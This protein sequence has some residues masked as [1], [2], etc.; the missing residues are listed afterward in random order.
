MSKFNVYA[1]R[2]DDVVRAYAKEYRLAKAAV[3]DAEEQ[4][5]KAKANMGLNAETRC[6]EATAA[7]QLQLARDNF[8]N[9]KFNL[10]KMND[11]VSA[12]RQELV[13]A[14]DSEYAAKSSDIDMQTME[15][16]KSGILTER[17]YVD[18]LAH[19]QNHTMKRLIAEKMDNWAASL[20]DKIKATH[21]RQLAIK[22]R[23]DD[24]REYV[25]AFDYLADAVNRTTKNDALFDRWDDIAKQTIESF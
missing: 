4:H 14:I 25:A 18:L 9:V 1:R 2:V 20:P 6:K 13:S 19:A 3:I 12:I 10:V 21:I 8:R 5:N 11:E 22:A 24:G 15:L 17:D 23:G 7:A 16:L